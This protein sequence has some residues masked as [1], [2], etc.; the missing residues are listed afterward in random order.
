M[1]S[2]RS[3]VAIS[4]AVASKRGKTPERGS[5]WATAWASS[6]VCSWK[7]AA[8]PPARRRTASNPCSR[9]ARA[10]RA[11][12]GASESRL[13]KATIAPG[14]ASL[15]VEGTLPA[16]ARSSNARETAVSSAGS[17]GYESVVRLRGSGIR[18]RLDSRAFK[19]R[20]RR[21]AMSSIDE[22]VQNNQ[23][24][25]ESFDKG[26]LPLPPA[27]GLAVI[28]C[29]D[30]RLNVHKLLGLEDGDARVIR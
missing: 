21:K 25:A 9:A 18:G 24:Y 6:T 30:A 1:P 5:A 10:A 22:V 11:Y 3:A 4:S 13:P 8:R 29:M 17:S 2:L 7:T 14:V 27:K 26:D 16:A 20:R 19:R 12:P 23:R 28:T 15:R